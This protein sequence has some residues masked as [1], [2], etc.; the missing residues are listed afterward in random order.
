MEEKNIFL[1]PI[2]EI[3]YDLLKSA[4]KNGPVM[5]FPALTKPQPV[6]LMYIVT[7]HNSPSKK[8]TGNILQEFL[9]FGSFIIL[10][11]LVYLIFVKI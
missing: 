2:G 6:L 10:Q 3:Y 8:H 7:Y 9:W 11:Y 4:H 1:I 5:K